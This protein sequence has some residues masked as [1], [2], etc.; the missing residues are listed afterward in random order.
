VAT[1]REERRLA[2]VLAADMVGYSRLMQAD[3]SGTIAR[4][5][6]YR[7]TL[8]D[9]TI[10]EY[11]GRIVKTTGDG[12]LVEFASVVDAV[13]CAVAVQRAMLEREADLP[14]D[15]RIR[16]R[17]GVNLGDIVVDGDDILGDGVN[18]AARLEGLA[19]VGG[20]CISRIVFESVKDK[21]A[22]GFEEMGAHKVKNLSEPVHAYRV[23]TAPDGAAAPTPPQ[24]IAALESAAKPCI[25]VLPFENLTGRPEQEYF[26][27]GITD[28]II[29]ELCRFRSLIVIARNSTFEFKGRPADVGEIDRELGA[30]YLVEG[31]VR[32]SGERVRISVQLIEAPSGNHLWAERYD[33]DLTDVFAVQD[34]VTQTI[35]ATLAVHVEDAER[36]R[37]R[38]SDPQNL[39]A[40]DCCLRGK[41]LFHQGTKEDVLQARALFERAIAMDP[42]YAA[43]YI[44]LGETYFLEAGSAWTTSP[45]AATQKVF[46]LAHKAAELDPYNSRAHLALAWGYMA[47]RSD[48]SLARAQIDE[49]LKLNPNDFDNYCFKGWLSTCSGEL[50]TAVACSNEALRRSPLVP[51]DCLY[52]R[53]AAE[54]LAGNYGDAILAFA[55]MRRP[56]ANASAWV[57]AAY[58]QLGRPG[59]ARARL[60]DFRR[61][62]GGLHGA[63]AGGDATGWLEYWRTA[64]PSTDGAMHEHLLDGLRKA[65]LEI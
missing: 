22:L 63:P 12:L 19:D 49:A 34:E 8:I 61:D 39:S 5:R 52:T 2:A 13:E 41:C 45:E 56:T 7:T 35:V 53:V 20:V 50:E 62:V 18:V 37:S 16:Y 6:E 42:N 51:D 25:A 40:Y 15:R 17:V 55:K 64:F 47:I 59:E 58:A 4:Q 36:L 48:F 54:Y 43:A 21:V 60:E 23:V 65:G 38:R 26:A 24:A 30:T 29:T 27:D 28:D 3:E 1:V 9:P 46:E 33:R 57:A 10:A 32:R 31:S 11:K 14:D 44:E